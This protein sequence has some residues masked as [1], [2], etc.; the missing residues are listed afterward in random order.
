MPAFLAALALLALETPRAQ[1]GFQAPLSFETSRVPV[2]LA[3]CRAIVA[4]FQAR[5]AYPLRR[6]QVPKSS[7]ATRER[8][9]AT[10]PLEPNS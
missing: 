3:F 5:W 1:P 10:C 2:C 4:G 9:L 6:A 8:Q 7:L